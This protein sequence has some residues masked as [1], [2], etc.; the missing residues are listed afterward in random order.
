MNR[1]RKLH[2]QVAPRDGEFSRSACRSWVGSLYF[3]P[4]LDRISCQ[5]CRM[6]IQVQL[7]ATGRQ[8]DRVAP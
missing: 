6:S 1:N 3:A 2:W 5:R 8:D 7:E 4:S